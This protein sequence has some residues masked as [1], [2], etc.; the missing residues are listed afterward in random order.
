VFIMPDWNADFQQL[1]SMP[2]SES[3]FRKLFHL[4]HDFVYCSSTYAKIIISELLLPDDEK[5]IKPAEVGGVAG[6]SKVRSAFSQS[7]HIRR[8]LTR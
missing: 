7:N 5:T 8:E 1:L 6:G 4:A 3:K 2:D